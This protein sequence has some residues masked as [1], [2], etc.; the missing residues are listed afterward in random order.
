[1]GGYVS[2]SIDQ[3]D[4]NTRPRGFGT[5]AMWKWCAPEQRSTRRVSFSEYSPRQMGHTAVPSSVPNIPS[6][7]KSV[8]DWLVD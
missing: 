5:Y 1:M 6:L 8:V 4:T 7:F 2:V 3:P